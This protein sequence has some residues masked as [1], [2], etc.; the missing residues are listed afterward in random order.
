MRSLFCLVLVA[1]IGA[2]DGAFA[3]DDRA[4]GSDADGEVVEWSGAGLSVQV[5]PLAA[6]PVQAFLLGRGFASKTARAYASNC[7]FR[8]ILHYAGGAPLDYDLRN[9]R[10]RTE[11][12]QTRLLKP[13]EDWLEDWRS[14][15]LDAAARMGFEF[16]QLPTRQTLARGDTVLGMSAIA[17]PPGSRFDLLLNWT[18]AGESHHAVVAGIRCRAP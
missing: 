9:W 7:V 2:V 3:N 12:G 16:S 8:V 6:D 17:L 5:K 13:R 10:I 18:I 4:Y 1:V 14:P 15:P 11:D